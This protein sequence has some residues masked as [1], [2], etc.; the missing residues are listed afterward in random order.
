MRR[1]VPLRAGRTTLGRAAGCDIRLDGEG[2][3]PRHA[4][5]DCAGGRVLL[6]AADA[7]VR[8]NGVAVRE[9][10]LQEGQHLRLGE[11]RLNVVRH[12]VDAEQAGPDQGSAV[13]EEARP[14]RAELAAFEKWCALLDELYEWS[15]VGPWDWLSIHLGRLARQLDAD[16]ALLARLRRREPPQAL[17]CAGAPPTE[18]W[19]EIETSARGEGLASGETATCAGSTWWGATLATREDERLALVCWHSG[20]GSARGPSPEAAGPLRLLLRFL[21]HQHLREGLRLQRAPPSPAGLVF[22][23]WVAI[24]E[25]PAMR[26]LYDEV[27]AGLGLELPVLVIGETGA[28]KEHVARLLHDSSR[29]REG[30]YVTINCAAIPAEL[31]ESELFGIE[32]G[33]AT[34]VNERRGKF[35][36]AQGGTLLLDEVGEL[37]VA[38][39][40]KLLRVL[41]DRQVRPVGGRST[42]L[43]VRIVAATNVDLAAEAAAR[44]FRQDLYYRLAGWVLRVPPLRERAEDLV[45]LFLRFL[46]TEGGP[47]APRALAA[48]AVRSLL[49]HTWPGN[50]RELRHEAMRAALRAR[51]GAVVEACHLSLGP[52][53]AATR[54][55]GGEGLDERLGRL[56]NELVREALARAGGNVS[57][58]ATELGISRA[59]LRRTMHGEPAGGGAGRGR[60]AGKGRRA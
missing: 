52:V 5:I 47:E 35:R 48:D 13:V 28:G 55:P 20:E 46:A 12:P 27:A 51:G 42:P 1:E 21:A 56:Q 49:G 8:L 32:R 39:Q 23:P 50:V 25:S 26:R 2:V 29:R 40:A 37:P 44:R 16:G 10:V 7:A 3:A 6:L 30:P 43:D 31:L 58:A 15:R 22:P 41:E 53:A 11:S 33:V 38:L 34:G 19:S 45:P 36:E 57:Q 9:A 24:G 4:V 54:K 14:G 17:G 60:G 59:R 18:L